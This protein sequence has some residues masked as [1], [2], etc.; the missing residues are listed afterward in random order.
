MNLKYSKIFLALLFALPLICHA[1]SNYTASELDTLVANIALYP[2]QLLIHVLDASTY[3]D[4][5]PGAAMWAESHKNL[6]GESLAAAIE[7]ANLPYEPCIQALIPFP[8]VLSM[9]NKY[10]VWTDQLGD[11]VTFQREA[12]MDAVQRL[13]NAAYNHGHLSSNELVKVERGENI[14]IV[15]VRE[16]YVYVPVYNPR[17]VYYVHANGYTHVSYGSGVWIGTWFGEWGWGS[18]WFDWGPRV[19]YV[20][21]TRWYAHRPIP[22]H[23]RRYR[24]EPRHKAP[25]MIPGSP[26]RPA[27]GIRPAAAAPRPTVVPAPAP[28]PTPA[29][30][31]VQPVPPPPKRVVNQDDDDQQKV[32]G[33]GDPTMPWPATPKRAE[34]KSH[35]P[36]GGKTPAPAPRGRW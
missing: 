18:C 33:R 17:V 4:Q 19:I 1:Q 28:A 9:L 31:K 6:K 15:P 27:A 8:T 30:A 24:P 32:H 7:N 3:G 13:R 29:P 10:R 20:R 12:V 26:V 34:P 16:E 2:D 22:H 23:P 21:N 14:V 36:K 5:I 11:A 25:P 35:A